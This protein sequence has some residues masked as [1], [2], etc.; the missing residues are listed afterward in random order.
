MGVQDMTIELSLDGR[1][2]GEFVGRRGK[3]SGK[4]KKQDNEENLMYIVTIVKNK[5]TKS[6]TVH[7]QKDP[8]VFK[9]LKPGVEVYLARTQGSDPASVGEYKEVERP[10]G[11]DMPVYATFP[12]EL[13]IPLV[14]AAKAEGY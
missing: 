7:V 14:A 1:Q 2:L 3:G 13:F 8:K 5:S 11:G 12:D 10:L 6:A 4:T 9:D